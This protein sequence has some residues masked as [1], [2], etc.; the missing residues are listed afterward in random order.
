MI[1]NYTLP[2][3]FCKSYYDYG[4]SDKPRWSLPTCTGDPTRLFQRSLCELAKYKGALIDLIE[5]HCKANPGKKSEPDHIRLA[6]E[7]CGL[8]QS[9]VNF[10]TVI[11]FGF[12]AGKTLGKVCDTPQ[13]RRWVE[14]AIRN[15]EITITDCTHIEFDELTR[16][17]DY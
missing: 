12:F 9:Q 14:S 8:K 7:V 13:G 3:T 1:I 10:T 17:K 11:L 15:N 4:G 16:E 5:A 2:G 6:R